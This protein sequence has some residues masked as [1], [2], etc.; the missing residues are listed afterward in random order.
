MYDDEEFQPD[1]GYGFN[2]AAEKNI[3]GIVKFL[4]DSS[5]DAARLAKK[6]C[7]KED[8]DGWNGVRLGF[9]LI[10]ILTLM[11]YM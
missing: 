10:F 4:N 5:S 8:I 1:M 2:L 7:S 6:A 3:T 9:R 11:C